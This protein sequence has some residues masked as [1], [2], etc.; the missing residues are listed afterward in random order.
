MKFLLFILLPNIACASIF[1]EENL[2]LIKLV[3]GQVVEL[4]RL[5]E[6]VGV[7]KE[8]REILLKINEGMNRVTNQINTLDEISRRSQNLN[9]NAIKRMSDL[10]D[11]LNELKYIKGTTEGV[12]SAKL[13]LADQAIAQSAL[14]SDTSYRMGQEMITTGSFLAK[15]SKNASPGRAAQITASAESASMLSNGVLLQ[16]LA[17]LTQLQ[18]VSL[19]LQK[20]QLEQNLNLERG[21]RNFLAYQVKAGKK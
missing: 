20:S 18:T 3:T 14:Q 10:T 13:A 11:Y 5:T 4:E 9:P 19:E 1:G 6:A 8:N 16:T 2:S 7:A 12:L 15:E 21:R 17:Q